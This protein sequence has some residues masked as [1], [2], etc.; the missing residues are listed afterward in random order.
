ML[1]KLY[2]DEMLK[3]KTFVSEKLSARRA[4][5]LML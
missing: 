1:L 2:S 4:F 5:L 3:M